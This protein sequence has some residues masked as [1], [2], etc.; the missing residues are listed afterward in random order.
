MTILELRYF[1]EVVRQRN[2][3]KAAE[4]LFVTEP[5]ISYHIKKLEKKVGTALLKRTTKY[6][7][8]TPEGELFY[9]QARIAVDAYDTL[10]QLAEGFSKQDNRQ[11]RLGMTPILYEYYLK[12]ELEQCKA[13][14]GETLDLFLKDE[15]YLLKGLQSQQIDFA[16]I[17]IYEFTKDYFDPSVYGTIPL[18]DE[19]VYLILSPKLVKKGQIS[20]SPKEIGRIPFFTAKEGGYTKYILEKLCMVYKCQIQNYNIRADDF[21]VLLSAVSDGKAATMAGKSIA[22]RLRE[23]YKGIYSV[24]FLPIKPSFSQCLQMIYLKDKKLSEREWKLIELLRKAN[25]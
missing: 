17:K 4:N 14:L 19:P 23:M 20:I 22:T 16:I 8:L 21:S 13:I 9:K 25:G 7:V 2:F 5:T 6:V 3:T 18:F 15:D 12:K 10:V 11:I 1:I 24:D